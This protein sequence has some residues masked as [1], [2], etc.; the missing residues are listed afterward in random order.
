LTWAS[1][2]SSPI[3]SRNSVPPEASTNLPTWRSVAPVKA[4]L[5]V[6]EQDRLD[7]VVRNRAA[8]HGD[9]GL[10]FAV[11]RAWMARARHLLA[12][13]GLALDQHRDVRLR[14]PLGEADHRVM[15]G[16]RV[17][18]SAEVE[19]ARGAPAH[20]ADLV[21]ERIDPHR[22]LDRDLAGARRRPA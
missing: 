17:A 11:A 14:G 8:V 20:A 12:D 21:L 18:R 19:R 4:S 2:G 22:V 9:E 5:L 16:L 10:A 6:A 7:E 13:A 15:S 1:S 3:S